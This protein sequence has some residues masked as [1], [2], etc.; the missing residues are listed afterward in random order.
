M[1]RRLAHVVFVTGFG[2]V[3]LVAGLLAAL[4]VA[5]PGRRLLARTVTTLSDRVFRGHLTIGDVSGNFLTTLSL[6]GVVLTDS[7]GAVVAEFPRL[8]LR[9]AAGIRPPRLRCCL[10]VPHR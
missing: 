2:T 9:R 3:A 8:D 5:P 1:R 7:S 4:T 6:A 10:S